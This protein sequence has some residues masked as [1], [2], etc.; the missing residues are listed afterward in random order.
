M[1]HAALPPPSSVFKQAAQFRGCTEKVNTFQ[2]VDQTKWSA[3]TS[4]IE[5]ILLPNYL[6]ISA[7]FFFFMEIKTLL[8]DIILEH[9]EMW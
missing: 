4:T 2:A 8:K 3:Y 9:A 6:F 7:Y 1:L 5:A